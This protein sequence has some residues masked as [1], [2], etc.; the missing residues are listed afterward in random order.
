[1]G[2]EIRHILLITQK[3]SYEISRPVGCLS[4]NKPF[5]F[6]A[7]PDPDPGIFNET[8]LPFQYS[9][10]VVSLVFIHSKFYLYFL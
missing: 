10:A 3:N 5:D 1:M 9:S 6:G 7:D 8:Y 4:S 2:R